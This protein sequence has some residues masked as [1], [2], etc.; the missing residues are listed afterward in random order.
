VEKLFITDLDGTLLNNKGKISDYS[1]NTIN[2]LI[3][4]GMSFTYATAR[5]LVSASVVTKG[6]RIKLPVITFNGTFIIDT[7]KNIELLSFYFNEYEINL[8]KD[9]FVKFSVNPLVY[10]FINGEEKVS[11]IESQENNGIKYYK[12]QR[13]GDKRLRPVQ[14][15]EEL[16]QGNIFYFMCI[17]E[18]NELIEMYDYCNNLN[19]FTCTFQREI[20]R[21]EYL[22]EI[23]PKNASKGNGI[24][25]LKK[26]LGFNKIITFGDA[27][28]DIPMF[29]ISDECYAVENAVDELKEIATEII[30]SNEDDGVAKW[31][32]ANIKV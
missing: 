23:Y 14:I 19:I 18:K 26:L 13:I 30:G 21:N 6:L 28:N 31:L 9:I 16:Y 2:E 29:K 12:S 24:V 17:G 5:S 25:N 20:Y 15:F 3:D 11:W 22:C 7:L 32:K 10:S 27:I 4:N 8:I 1:I